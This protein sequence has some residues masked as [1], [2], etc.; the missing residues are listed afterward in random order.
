MWKILQ[1][2]VGKKTA[3]SNVHKRIRYA[4][5]NL[6]LKRLIKEIHNI[7]DNKTVELIASNHVVANLEP[8]FR[9]TVNIRSLLELGNIGMKTT[10]SFAAT[11]ARTDSDRLDNLENKFKRSN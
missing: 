9:E 1:T 3:S 6:E 10:V 8:S 5:F 2:K 4:I 11:S 7:E